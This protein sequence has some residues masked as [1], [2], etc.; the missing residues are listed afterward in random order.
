VP[1]RAPHIAQHARAKVRGTRIRPCVPFAPLSPLAI[2]LLY[3]LPCIYSRTLKKSV[4]GLVARVF[5]FPVLGQSVKL[6]HLMLFT[7]AGALAASIRTLAR[8]QEQAQAMEANPHAQSSP[9]M[10]YDAVRLNKRWRAER[11][12]WL[13]AF[14]FTMWTVLAIFYRE[15]ARR[16][17]AEDRLAEFETSDCTG[18]IDSTIRDV[19]VSKEVTSRPHLLSPR[20]NG[21]G[22]D[23]RSSPYA[24]MAVGDGGSPPAIRDAMK[25]LGTASNTSGGSSGRMAKKDK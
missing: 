8:L 19:S 23:A 12:L 5:E 10:M 3:L 14:A 9:M 22:K 2:S 13:S 11:N 20:T 16:L 21:G 7:L 15:M 18:T 25:S 4:V 1:Y 6:L 17:R 24:G